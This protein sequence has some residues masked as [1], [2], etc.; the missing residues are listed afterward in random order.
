MQIPQKEETA[1]ID[2]TTTTTDGAAEQEVEVTPTV[3]NNDKKVPDEVIIDK[4]DVSS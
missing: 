3:V 2:H 4:K 1:E